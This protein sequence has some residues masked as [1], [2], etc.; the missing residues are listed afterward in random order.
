VLVHLGRRLVCARY[1][2]GH[3]IKAIRLCEDIAYN[4]RRTHGPRSPATIET[5]ELLAELYTST[6]QSYQAKASSEKTGPLAT[7]YFKKA[8]A[9]HEDLLRLLVR[10]EG[11]AD[12][13]DEE[14]TTAALLAEHG[15]SVNG[16]SVDGREGDDL[17]QSS[18]NRS[19]LSIRH[20]HLLKFAYQRLGGWPKDAREYERLNAELFR[21]F[22]GEKEW[23]G[24]QGVEKWSVKEYG[25]GKAESKDGAFEG[26]MDWAF[27]QSGAV[28]ANGKK[29]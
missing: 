4:L 9:V 26:V 14:D 19:E 25:L 2:A 10:D 12:S 15:V 20:L 28:E 13:D 7:Q 29:A 17:E 22:G 21:V 23:K 5:Y 3:P 27:A 18:I 24:A 11:D 16:A 8:L 1:L 6:G